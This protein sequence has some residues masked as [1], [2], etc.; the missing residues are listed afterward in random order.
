MGCDRCNN[1]FHASSMCV[2]LPSS[3]IDEIRKYGGAGVAF[4]CI[5]CQTCVPATG[6]DG[7]SGPD[8]GVDRVALASCLKP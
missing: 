4:I 3:L 8:G 6:G 7:Q 5:D 1:W 2:G